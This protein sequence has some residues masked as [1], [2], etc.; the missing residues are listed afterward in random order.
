MEEKLEN[1]KR[2]IT[3]AATS[4]MHELSM[5]Q[6]QSIGLKN[7]HK[8][9][10][11]IE[12]TE[13]MKKAQKGGNY[14]KKKFIL[15]AMDYLK[16]SKT[17][18]EKDITKKIKRIIAEGID[19]G[20]E[21]SPGENGLVPKF[22]EEAAAKYVRD[23]LEEELGR[24]LKGMEHSM[25]EDEQITIDVEPGTAEP[26]FNLSLEDADSQQEGHF[27]L[28][29]E[30]LKKVEPELP[31][32]YFWLPKEIKGMLN[33][34]LMNDFEVRSAIDDA[35][36]TILSPP[37]YMDEIPRIVEEHIADH[38]LL[39]AALGIEHKPDNFTL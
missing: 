29:A 18:S 26:K 12:L 28:T 38:P 2:H 19:K 8:L 32:H 14:E 15:Q 33:E 7:I 31:P 5:R 10:P 17:E 35:T 9:F 20:I 16:T 24:I 30:G 34:E 1:V 23:G 39:H 21:M 11:L 3:N 13:D 6:M 37:K 25:K 36:N 27:E 22:N 4:K